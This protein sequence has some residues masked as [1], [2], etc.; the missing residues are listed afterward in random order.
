MSP[1]AS[2]ALESG[3]RWTGSQDRT[4][5]AAATGFGE[6]GDTTSIP[7][8]LRGRF[9]FHVEYRAPLQSEAFD[10]ARRALANLAGG[11]HGNTRISVDVDPV[12]MM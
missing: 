10:V 12:S 7:V 5:I 9:R 4:A 6:A 11:R 1:S 3:I 2:F 8:T